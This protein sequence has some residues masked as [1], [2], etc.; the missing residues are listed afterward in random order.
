MKSGILAA[1]RAIEKRFN[2]RN[3]GFIQQAKIDRPAPEHGAAREKS[4]VRAIHKT[5]DL[6]GP[7]KSKGDSVLGNRALNLVLG[8]AWISISSVMMSFSELEFNRCLLD[9]LNNL[10]ALVVERRWRRKALRRLLEWRRSSRWR[11]SAAGRLGV[12]KP[13]RREVRSFRLRKDW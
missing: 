3:L 6:R 1:Q 9:S 10:A 13:P 5:N 11:W 7:D 8:I 12:G 4:L 2:R